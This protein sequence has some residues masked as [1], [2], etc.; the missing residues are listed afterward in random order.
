MENGAWKLLG[1]TGESRT[2]LCAG[3]F[4]HKTSS[5]YYLTHGRVLNEALTQVAH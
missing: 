5:L 1:E 2:Q 3:H 4:F